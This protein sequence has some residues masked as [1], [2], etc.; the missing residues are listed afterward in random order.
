MNYLDRF[1]NYI[2]AER[3][4]SPLTVRN[5]RR[6]IELF[7]AWCEQSAGER[8]DPAGI[9]VDDIREWIVVRSDEKKCKKDEPKRKSSS[10]NR[11]ISSLRSFFKYLRREG[12]VAT[13]IFANISSL[14]APKRL[15]VF[16]P[17]SKMPNLIGELDEE[18]GDGD[19]EG[20]RDALIILMFYGCGLRLAEL[21]GIGV[22]DFSSDCSTLKVRGK[23]DKE[24][25]IPVADAVRRQL[26]GYLELR[27]Q[28]ICTDGEKSLFLTREGRRISRSKVYRI[29][30]ES[31]AK[32]GVQGK[33][34]PHVLRHTFATH[35]L[36]AGADM[37]DIQELMGHSSLQTT[38]VYTHNSIARLREV[39]AKAHPRQK[40]GKDKKQY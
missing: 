28:N 31:L 30:R 39:Y 40:S 3:R 25:I 22:D 1:I 8:F 37:R 36:N 19:F 12:V 15:P 18:S 16:I 17:E 29:V 11:E 21:V 32:A 9:T 23:G 35:L 26:A 2:E 10:V 13:D 33:K 38:Q 5:Y 20:V 14:K 24:R 7:I 34:S 27:G 6:D 4:Y